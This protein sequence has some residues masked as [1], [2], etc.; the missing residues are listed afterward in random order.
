MH[1][2]Q[3]VKIF[4]FSWLHSSLTHLHAVGVDHDAIIQNVV[5]LECL[6]S[7]VW[8]LASSSVEEREF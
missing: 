1:G 4:V 7:E 8:I 6:M 3:N 2:Q 5:R